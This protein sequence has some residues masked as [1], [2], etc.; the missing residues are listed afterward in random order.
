MSQS[1]KHSVQARDTVGDSQVGDAEA[2]QEDVQQHSDLAKDTAEDSQ[3]G[4]AEALQ[5]DVQQPGRSQRIKTLTEKGKEMQEG[6]MKALQ[7]RLNYIYNKWKIHA[8][9]ADIQRVYGELRTVS[10]PSQETR[11]KV[12]LCVKISQFIVSKA[13]SQLEGAAPDEDKQD[14]PEAGPL[15]NSTSTSDKSSSA[16]SFLERG[17]EHSSRSSEDRKL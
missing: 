6:K 2:L 15:F 7:Q 14:W 10:T 3:V 8:K 16:A 5:E 4:D 11:H 13:S 1:S 12:D 9:T 17:S